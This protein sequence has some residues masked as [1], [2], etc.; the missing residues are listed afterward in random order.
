MAIPSEKLAKS[1][2]A[3]KQYQDQGKVALKASDFSRSDRE[4]LQQNN[5]IRNVMKGWFIPSNPDHR[6]GDSTP[7][8][9]SFWA[10]CSQYLDDR[11]DGNWSLSPEQ[12]LSLH[13]GNW[14]IPDQ[15]LVRAQ[16]GGNNITKLPFNT[17]L[18]D[19]ASPEA[20]KAEGRAING[21]RVYSVSSALTMCGPSYYRQNP[22]D[23]R[24]ALLSVTDSSQVLPFL[25][26]KNKTVI[27]G[28]LVGAF[29]NIGRKDIAD[30]IIST[31][32]SISETLSVTDPFE[33]ESPVLSSGRPQSAYVSRLKLMWENMRD[34]VIE[35]MPKEPG[36]HDDPKT[37]LARVDELFID[38]AYNSLSIEGYKVT[39][40]LIEK[41]RS[42]KWDPHGSNDD[43]EERNALAARGYWEAFKRVKSSIEKVLNGDNSG[44]VLRSD[45][46]SWYRALFSPSVTA[47]IL[48]PEDLAGYRNMAVI[49]RGSRHTTLSTEAVRDAMPALFDLL[50]QEPSAPVRAVMGHFL[51]GYIHPYMDGNGR[52]ARFLM[53]TMLASGG[54]EW[55]VI[56]VER[57]ADYMAA[58]ESASVDGNIKPFAT[59]ISEFIII[60]KP[61]LLGSPEIIKALDP[62][63]LVSLSEKAQ[64]NNS[65]ED[66]G[67]RSKR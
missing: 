45:H 33:F 15:L 47:G 27:A 41:V 23:L 44:N 14:T 3:L 20:S 61:D 42:G 63:N 38:D 2:M 50:E 8:Y 54:Y 58:L 19:I 18:L 28:R 24:A 34:D 46:S 16:K 60:N 49:I 65:E 62:S 52:T 25:L 43:K 53:N 59:F 9:A 29:N 26:E 35:I 21:V 40:A 10:F 39:E 13:A 48:N 37:Y 31:F 51:M 55:S 32:K 57:R 6:D 11:F 5:F 12:S 30:D 67:F 64:E 1:L 4:R 36:R 22:T 7:W 56:P 66:P 17:S